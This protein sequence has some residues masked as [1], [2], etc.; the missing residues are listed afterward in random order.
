MKIM[1]ENLGMIKRAEI[2]PK[3]LTVI[4]GPNNSC[5]HT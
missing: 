1:M 5:K 3:K 2:E 4:C